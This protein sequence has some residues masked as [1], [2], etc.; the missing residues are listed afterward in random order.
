MNIKIRMWS[1]NKMYYDTENVI[2]CL[3]Q[4][5]A[6]DEKDV[7]VVSY[8]H[9]GLHGSSFMLWTG[10]V[11]KNGNQIWEGDNV[12]IVRHGGILIEEGTIKFMRGAFIF[13]PNNTDDDFGDYIGEYKSH[14]IEVTG[15]VHEKI[16]NELTTN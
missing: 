8:D 11:D 13:V 10:L 1:G 7:K 6:F 3:S 15:N 5:T 12:K 4:Q 16:K 2:D 9:I 14:I